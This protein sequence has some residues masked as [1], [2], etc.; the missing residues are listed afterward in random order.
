MSAKVIFALDIGGT[1][2]KYGIIDFKYDI[3]FSSS[4]KTKKEKMIFQVE[5]LILEAKKSYDFDYVAISSAGVVDSNS[6]KITYTNSDYRIWTG[7]DF[8]IVARNTNT[9]IAMIND[10]NAAALSELVSK[11]HDSFVS[12]TLGTGL[13]A[14]IV[15]N[16]EIFQGKNFLG[17]EIGN[18]LAFKNQKEK[19]NEGLSF[20]RFNKKISQKFKIK[21]KTPS[22]YYPKLY[23]ENQDFKVLFNNYASKLAYWSFVIAIIL[24]VDHVYIG[25]AFSFVDDFLF[26]KAKDI[27]ISMQDDSPYKISFSKASYKN[28]AG[29][30]GATYFLK[31]KFNLA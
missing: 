28:N 16:G 6:N 7:F 29:I 2:I 27:F 19:I 4:V 11:K 14:G 24:N 12:I 20:S 23:K 18:N 26:D 31:Q 8:N 10:A 21:S 22:V 5:K 9:K 1:S 15:Y 13:G 17:G 3:L 25:G 30:I